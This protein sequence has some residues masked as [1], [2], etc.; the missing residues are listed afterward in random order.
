[1]IS[2]LRRGKCDDTVVA[3]DVRDI[4]YETPHEL[5]SVVV[6]CDKN[7]C[8]V[9]SDDAFVGM[10]FQDHVF[11]A[12]V[13]IVGVGACEYT[14]IYT[15]LLC[16]LSHLARSLGVVVDVCL[17]DSTHVNDD[18]VHFVDNP[19]FDMDATLSYDNLLF[20][21][22]VDHS[23]EWSWTQFSPSVDFV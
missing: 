12:D 22:D 20:E 15:P 19:I 5:G 4:S 3:T 1:M 13:V 8:Q 16:R 9:E 14:V 6:E 11:D 17:D 23:P 2:L 21:V 10:S 7:S 18:E